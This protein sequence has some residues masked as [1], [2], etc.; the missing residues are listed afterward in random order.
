MLFRSPLGHV[1]FQILGVTQ[2]K[3]ATVGI[4]GSSHIN[5]MVRAVPFFEIARS[6]PTS[7]NHPSAFEPTPF[8][9]QSTLW[10]FTA[11]IRL[12]TGTMRARMG[13]YGVMANPS[14]TMSSLMPGMHNGMP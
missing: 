8:Y 11:G 14:N 5:R 10:S 7:R 9:G 1:E 13:R 4:E 3:V 12:Q 6:V 2:W